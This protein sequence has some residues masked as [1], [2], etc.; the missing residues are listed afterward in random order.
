MKHA[1]DSALDRLT[2]LLAAVRKFELV[3]E[4]S[5]GVFYCRSKPLL[6]FHE[7]AAAGLFA[8]LRIG[9]DWE[10]MPVNAN[11]EQAKLLRRIR[12]RLVIL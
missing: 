7:D 5:R 9:S 6:H 1:T 2:S 3:R 12:H 8:D 11:D 10:R 4:K